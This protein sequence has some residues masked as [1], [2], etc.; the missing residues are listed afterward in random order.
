MADESDS[1][2]YDSTQSDHR[3]GAINTSVKVANNIRGNFFAG[4]S[5]A[6]AILGSDHY[7]CWYVRNDHATETLTNVVVFI[8]VNTPHEDDIIMIGKGTSAI[9]GTEQTIADIYTPPNSVTWSEAPTYNQGVLLGTLKPGESQAF[10]IWDKI[11]PTEVEGINKAELVIA[12][13]PPAG[14]DGSGSGSGG[15]TPGGGGGGSTGGGSVQDFGVAFTGDW[16][17][18][19]DASATVKNIVSFSD[20][21]TTV[22][23]GDNSYTDAGDKWADITA[24]LRKGD[25]KMVSAFGNHDRKEG[26]P[27]PELTN[28][29]LSLFGI[30]N[31]G[32]AYFDYTVG[33]MYIVFVDC[34]STF[35]SGST[36]YNWV[37]DKMEK[38]KNNSAINWRV[39][40]GHEPIYT[41]PTNYSSTTSLRDAYHPLMVANNFD[42]WFNGHNHNYMR[43][44][45]LTYNS[46]SPG[47]P[48]IV[49]SGDEPNY[50]NPGGQI[51]IQVG[52]AGRSSH[53]SFSGTAA[54]S[55]AQQDSSYGFL[56]VKVTLNGSNLTGKFYRNNGTLFDQFTIVK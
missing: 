55:A 29:Y 11:D 48:T 54:F 47:S 22:G 8:D 21:L 38:A 39:L 52:S 37:K 45:P 1:V 9:N 16:S 42:L 17:L 49:H 53:R 51:I 7:G 50:S 25:R 43:T 30:S 31:D 41:S 36:Q 19:S 33:N 27:Q 20:T 12:F 2:I 26:T 3:G 15:G 32:N 23:T 10:W 6:D 40:V 4:V 14:S 46:G 35:T 44:F 13:D 5:R 24:D 34:Y 28:F 18:S 56:Q